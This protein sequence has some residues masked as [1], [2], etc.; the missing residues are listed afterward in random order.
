MSGNIG[1]SFFFF[2][3]VFSR[4]ARWFGYTVGLEHVHFQCEKQ[5]EHRRQER[6]CANRRSEAVCQ[7]YHLNPLIKNVRNDDKGC[8]RALI[9]PTPTS[10]ADFDTTVQGNRYPVNP[11]SNVMNPIPIPTSHI[12]IPRLFVDR[13]KVTAHHVHEG[14]NYHRISCVEVNRLKEASVTDV[15]EYELRGRISLRWGGYVVQH[16]HYA[17]DS[18]N[19]KGNHG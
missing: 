9:I 7:C 17:G 15:L 10:V 12:I 1:T 8:G 11:K 13:N 19:H 3:G 14:K 18:L 5:K 6:R 2:S 16:Q 4:P